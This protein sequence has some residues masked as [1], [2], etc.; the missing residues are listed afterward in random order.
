MNRYKELKVWQE[1]IEFVTS[2][3]ALT[4]KFPKEELYG[5]TSQLNR[6]SVSIAANI[7]EG[8]GRNSKKEFVQFLSI[9]TGSCAEVETLLTIAEKIGY[10]QN[11]GYESLISKLLK[12]QNMLYRLQVVTKES[13]RTHN[14]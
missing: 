11:I 14:T 8:S 6:A 3:Y 4:K 10:I 5:L 7:A 13:S 9:S 1:A 2:I 12:I